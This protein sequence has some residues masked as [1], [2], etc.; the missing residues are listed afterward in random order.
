MISGMARNTWA[1]TAL[2]VMTAVAIG[3]GVWALSRWSALDCAT[4]VQYQ[5]DGPS[6]PLDAGEQVVYQAGEPA[7]TPADIHVSSPQGHPVVVTAY[8]GES[9]NRWSY[10]FRSVARFDA[11]TSGR[12]VITMR[13]VSSD[14]VIIAP[15]ASRIQRWGS[16][17]IGIGL[18][19]AL[20]I[21]VLMRFT[22]LALRRRRY[23]RANCRTL[24]S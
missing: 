10:G 15:S 1:V 5:L 6:V 11:P 2:T 9:L 19:I 23:A 7:V 13:G 22:V 16:L 18:L 21:A 8:R 14:E 3:C 4:Q 24:P 20:E 17:T 12:Y